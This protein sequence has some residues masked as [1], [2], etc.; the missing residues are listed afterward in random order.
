MG[1]VHDE[2]YKIKIQP[3]SSSNFEL[4]GFPD[5]NTFQKF[6]VSLDTISNFKDMSDNSQT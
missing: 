2:E 6:V 1:L 5:D 4:H 3:S